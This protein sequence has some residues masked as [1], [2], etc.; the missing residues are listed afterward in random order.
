MNADAD[1]ARLEMHEELQSHATALG[2]FG[3][4]DG[5]EP[6]P[7]DSWALTEWVTVASWT[8]LATGDSRLTRLSSSNLLA[9][10][11]NGLLHEALNTDWTEAD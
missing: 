3:D 2:P 11:R 4:A 8:N 7:A 6:D 10:H 1:R 5:F 9:H